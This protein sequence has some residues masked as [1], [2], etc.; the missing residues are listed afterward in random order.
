MN[1]KSLAIAASL[2]LGLAFGTAS[3]A[4]AVVVN[5]F[6]VRD[7]AT[8]GTDSFGYFQSHTPSETPFADDYLFSVNTG[9]LATIELQVNNSQGRLIDVTTGSPGIFTTQLL[10]D[11]VAIG[12]GVFATQNAPNGTTFTLAFADLQVGVIYTLEILGT[13]LG[14]AG[15]TYTFSANL[16]QVPLPAAVWLLLSAMLGLLPFFRNR[17]GKAHIA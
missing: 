1:M 6:G 11:G 15:G 10:A 13:V 3:N 2:A 8:T 17:R 16:S 12:S 4:S 7:V 5:D 14:Q 9:A